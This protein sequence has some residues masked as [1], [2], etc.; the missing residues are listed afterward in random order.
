MDDSLWIGALRAAGGCHLLTLVIACFTPIPD[1]WDENLAKLPEVHR[2]FSIAQNVAIG[3]TIA[4]CGLISLACAPALVR[5]GQAGRILCAGIALWWAGRLVILPW[6]R[7]GPLLK[8][9]PLQVGF[10]LLHLECA[11]F[12]AGY[13]WLAVRA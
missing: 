11:A 13:G 6:L 12:A 1:Q 8:T 2:R 10:V 5:G 4:F 7:V 9:R 3:A